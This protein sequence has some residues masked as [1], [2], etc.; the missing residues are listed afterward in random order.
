MS[1]YATT[2]QIKAA[3]RITDSVDDSLI[4]TAGSAASELIDAYCGRTFGQ[5]AG[6][7]TRYYSAHKSN[8]IEIDDMAA[9]PVFVKYSTNRDGNYDAT[10][11]PENYTL[12]P[13]NGI[14]DGLPWPYTAIQ[15]LNTMTWTM[16]VADEPTV[17]VSAVWGFPTVPASVL[18]AAI[19]QSARIFARLSS[20]LGVTA[21]EFGAVRMLS[22][23]DP[24]V[25]VL[26]MPYRKLRAAL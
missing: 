8:H 3:L 13:S 2:A 21:G 16:A 4:N 23:V 25:E 24:D 18:Q 1:L 20:P 19:M 14:M 17:S 22:K 6:T 10:V 9:A 11:A 5:S 7:V 15:T 12:L 26:L